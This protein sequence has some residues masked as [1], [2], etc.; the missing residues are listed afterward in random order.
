M[1]DEPIFEN[2]RRKRVQAVLYE[3][4]WIIYKLLQIFIIFL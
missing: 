1:I 4:K 3:N 2:V